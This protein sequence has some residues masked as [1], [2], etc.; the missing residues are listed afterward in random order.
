MRKVF[1]SMTL[2]AAILMMGFTS[3][4]ND[5]NPADGGEK[6][7]PGKDTYMQVSISQ[8]NAPGTYA[9]DPNSTTDESHFSTVDIFVYDETVKA[10]EAHQRLMGTDFDYNAG[11]G[12]GVEKWEAKS[13]TKVACKTGTKK[14]LAALN[15]SEDRGKAIAAKGYN[16]FTLD[17]ATGT[18][19]ET[20]FDVTNYGTTDN[21]LVDFPTAPP[22]TGRGISMFSV[23]PIAATLVSDA[24]QN[25]VTIPVQ[26]LV[27]KVTMQKGNQMNV[28]TGGGKIVGDL[29]F[30]LAT[31]NLKTYLM[32]NWNPSGSG[33]VKDHNW[34]DNSWATTDFFAASPST[35][36]PLI[37][38][39]KTVN[40]S[41]AVLADL[42][43]RYCPENTS[44]KFYQKEVTT[45]VV[46]CKYIPGTY[47]E[48]DGAGGYND[49]DN[50]A[51]TDAVTFYTVSLPDGTKQ[52]FM[53]PAVADS[54][55]SANG[56][57]RFD[58]DQGYCYYRVYLNPK[59]TAKRIELN[60][61][62]TELE[63]TPASAAGT[64]GA[65]DVI[66]NAY[67]KVNITKIVAPGNP[68]P[69]PR[70]PDL[71]V[72][73]PTDII[74]TIDIVHWDVVGQDEELTPM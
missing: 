68:T 30:A 7:I 8:P 4:N 41:G 15:I 51:A 43:A 47:K 40:E 25:T 37:T 39:Y 57:Q 18:F 36:A 9:N 72:E 12:T 65:Y 48:S 73:T 5:D 66:R 45:A 63:T 61:T 22:A 42:N 1:F 74:A 67:Y 58:Y 28:E 32:R 11:A 23:G 27:S 29:E 56:G 53:D 10:L 50:T 69:E 60:T 35:T 33:A 55:I 49:V 52:Y 31:T 6:A 19:T 2:A 71:P 21:A 46:R 24:S 20:L 16:I 54:Y 62:G 64:V 17:A 14:I 38:E 44:E 3:C 70:N 26:R 13:T 34:T 59:G